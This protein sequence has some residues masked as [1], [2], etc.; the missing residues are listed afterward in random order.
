MPACGTVW[1]LSAL[2]KGFDKHKVSVDLE[3][4]LHM[5]SGRFVLHT[6]ICVLPHHIIDRLHYIHHLLQREGEGKRARDD[7]GY[8]STVQDLSI[9][10]Q[11][12]IDGQF[13]NCPF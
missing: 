2:L 10:L 12:E 4:A 5:F 3:E 11:F 13:K 1:G 9:T 6:G 8:T 7:T